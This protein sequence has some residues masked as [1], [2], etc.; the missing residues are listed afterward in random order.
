MYQWRRAGGSGI[1]LLFSLILASGKFFS[2]WFLAKT[3]ILELKILH[4]REFWGQN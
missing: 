4:F 1:C 2:V 3:Q